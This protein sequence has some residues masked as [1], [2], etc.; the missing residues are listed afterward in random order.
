VPKWL[1]VILIIVGVI[2]GLIAL[3]RL[4]LWM[5]AKG[6]IYWRKVKPR[7]GGLA[8]GLMAMQQFIE[9]DVRH[10]REERD[11]RRAADSAEAGSNDPASELPDPR[12]G[13]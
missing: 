6:W 5:E 1:I 12:D 2:G 9:P 3:D 11:Q 13:D 4:L 7:G 8:V 10:V